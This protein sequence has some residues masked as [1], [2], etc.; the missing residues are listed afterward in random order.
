VSSQ[1]FRFIRTRR[2]NQTNSPQREHSFLSHPTS[3]QAPC[4]T[5]AAAAAAGPRWLFSS[6]QFS[7]AQLPLN[8]IPSH[9]PTSH[10]TSS[11]CHPRSSLHLHLTTRTSILLPSLLSPLGCFSSASSSSDLSP[12]ACF[13]RI[14]YEVQ[15]SQPVRFYLCVSA[16]PPHL[17]LF[18]LSSNH[19][20][21][22]SLAL[23]RF[24]LLT[25]ITSSHFSLTSLDPEG[26]HRNGRQQRFLRALLLHAAFHGWHVWPARL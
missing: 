4:L 21:P 26:P 3:G 5:A 25:P 7:S 13:A 15:V 8:R 2:S 9:S 18:Y 16:S 17:P 6:V 1:A 11:H 24:H 20:L 12:P 14:S 23:P 22:V 19:L 10:L